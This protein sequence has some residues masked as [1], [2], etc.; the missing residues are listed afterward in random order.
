MKIE[1]ISW[2]Q[3]AADHICNHSVSPQEVEEV[4]FNDLDSPVIMRGKEGKYLGRRSQ[5][6]SSPC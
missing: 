6:Q 1:R 5:G 3:E 4:L 2:D